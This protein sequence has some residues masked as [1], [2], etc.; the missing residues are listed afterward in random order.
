[1]RGFSRPHAARIAIH[2][3]ENLA[4]SFPRGARLTLPRSHLLRA[5]KDSLHR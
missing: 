1:M 5:G 3:K 4:F 2:V